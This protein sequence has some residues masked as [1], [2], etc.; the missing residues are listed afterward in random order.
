MSAVNEATA[1]FQAI[2]TI[3]FFGKSGPGLPDGADLQ[4]RINQGAPLLPR[5]YD[6]A[7]TDP[8]RAGLPRLLALAGQNRVRWTSVETV[9]GAIYQHAPDWPT[10]PALRRFVAVVSNLWRSY[11]DAAR[12]HEAAMPEI[13]AKL[14]P[15]AAFGHDGGDGPITLPVDLIE[16]YLQ[17]GVGVVSLPATMADH[18]ILWMALAHETGG[19]D[20]T[21]ADPGLL[22]EFAARLA[23][24]LAPFAPDCGLAADD[25]SA[26]W[27]RWIDEATADVYAL[28]NAGPAFAENMIVML[29][30][31]GG[32]PTPTLRLECRADGR[33]LLDA[34]PVDLLRVHVLLGALDSLDGFSGRAAARR[35][36]E[37][38]ADAFARGDRIALSGDLPTGPRL[39]RPFAADTRRDGMAR[40]AEAVGRL[41]ATTPLNELGRVPIQRIET[42]D[43]AD[44]AAVATI[45]DALAAGRPIARLGDD[46]QLLAA[47]CDAVMTDATTYDTTTRELSDA[48][49]ESFRTDPIWSFEEPDRMYLRY[50]AG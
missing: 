26:V 1:L 6:A 38:L 30:A 27:T 3:D 18:P 41:I 36:L 44:A 23:P 9:A 33:G 12:R 7:Y 28:L 31:M 34:H 22:D 43:D 25:L 47:A 20:I 13:G 40:A 17:G 8:V 15:L 16:S 11:L 35:R 21:H 5:G 10:A 2:R 24:A 49:D 4:T 45:R 29:A 50:G 37:D 46:A 39:A 19:H 32:A 42:W 48:L 14:P